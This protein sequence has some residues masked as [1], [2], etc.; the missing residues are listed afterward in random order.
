MKKEQLKSKNRP[1]TVKENNLFCPVS[2]ADP[3]VLP[4]NWNDFTETVPVTFAIILCYVMKWCYENVLQN[5][6]LRIL[7]DN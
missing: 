3:F 1:H 4:V 5:V 2:L 6:S 7:T